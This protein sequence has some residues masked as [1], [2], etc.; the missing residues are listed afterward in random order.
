MTRLNAVCFHTKSNKIDQ[1]EK[2]SEY[3]KLLDYYKRCSVD[4]ERG[5]YMKNLKQIHEKA[6]AYKVAEEQESE[7]KE[8]YHY[9]AV[10]EYDHK[11]W[12]VDG[13]KKEP[14]CIQQITTSFVNDAMDFIQNRVKDASLFSILTFSFK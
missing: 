6:V 2:G 9:E 13:R 14:V 11:I 5:E 12:L 7:T 1:I 8:I 4:K 3:E 10:I